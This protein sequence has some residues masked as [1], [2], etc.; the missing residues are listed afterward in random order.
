MPEEISTVWE[1]SR[2]GAKECR[3]SFDAVRFYPRG[4]PTSPAGAFP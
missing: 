3:S 1:E 2:Q 4:A